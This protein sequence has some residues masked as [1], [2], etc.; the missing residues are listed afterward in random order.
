MLSFIVC[1][2]RASFLK[3]IKNSLVILLV[4]KK[5]AVIL[6]KAALKSLSDILPLGSRFFALLYAIVIN[7][8]FT[9]ASASLPS[10]RAIKSFMLFTTPTPSPSSKAEAPNFSST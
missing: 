2:A 6:S 1:A 8:D 7:P 4:A 5:E 9:W 3:P 10:V